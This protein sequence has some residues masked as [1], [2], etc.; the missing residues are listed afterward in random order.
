MAV[1]VAG[2][3]W[4]FWLIETEWGVWKSLYFTL[5]TVTTVGYGDQGLSDATAQL[6]ARRAHVTI[7]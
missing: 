3:T 1:V 4:G 2:G 6:V 7:P 5:I